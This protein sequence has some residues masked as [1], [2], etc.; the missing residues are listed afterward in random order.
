MILTG[1]SRRGNTAVWNL[2][3]Y[4]FTWRLVEYQESPVSGLIRALDER[5]IGF[6]TVTSRTIKAYNYTFID[7]TP[8]P[9]FSDNISYS[10]FTTCRR[11][12]GC[13][14]RPKISPVKAEPQTDKKTTRTY[15]HRVKA[16]VDVREFVIVRD[17]FIDFEVSLHIIYG[18]SV[19]SST[20]SHEDETN[21]YLPPCQAAQCAPSHLRKRSHA[22]HAR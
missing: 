6:I 3:I 7:N 10:M 19:W 13:N 16:L 5:L 12:H 1:P 15:V 2:L 22:R 8:H 14:C 11:Q 4:H 9:S 20:K 17:I 18:E 21:P